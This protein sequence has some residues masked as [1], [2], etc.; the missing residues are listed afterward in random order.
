[1]G[2][3]KNMSEFKPIETQEQFDAAITERIARAKEA[4][5]KEFDG[6][7]SPEQQKKKTAELETKVSGL[8]SQLQEANEKITQ[9]QTQIAERDAKIAKYETDSAKTR[10]A[11]ELGL[12]Y[13][14]VAY[15]RGENEDEI[16]KSAEGLKTII[17]IRKAPPLA[18]PEGDSGTGEE[19]AA[20]KK[21]LQN[22]KGE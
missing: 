5:R 16:R 18:D 17:G 15:L 21:M 11:N 6:W 1:M 4:T 19:K 2:K 22:M 7:L 8:T 12:S 13:E 14:A 9:N 20:Y 3:G 10:I